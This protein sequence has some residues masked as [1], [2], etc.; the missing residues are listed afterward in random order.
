MT[1]SRMAVIIASW[2]IIICSLLIG[3]WAKKKATDV[4]SFF[5]S[6]ALFGPITIGL[7]TMA[8]VAS[9]F[10]VV[11]VPGLLYATGNTIS[12]WILSSVAFSMSYIILGKKMRAMAELGPVATLGDICDLRFNRHKGIKL[13]FSVIIFIG[14]IA[15]LA[16]QIKGVSELFAHLMGWSP[17]LSAF[18]IFGV[19]TLYTAIS[20]EVGGIMT[21]AFQGFV[22]VLA[23]FIMIFSFYSIT[24]GMFNAVSVISSAGKITAGGITKVF[25]PNMLNAWGLLPGSTALAFIIMP[26]IGLLGQPQVLT[27]MYALKNPNDMAKLALYASFSH[28]FVSFLAVVT[29]VGAMYLVAKGLVSPI[30]VADRAVFVFADYVGTFGQVFVYACVLSAAMSSASMFLSLSAG[31]LSRDIPNALGYKLTPDKQINYA[32]VTIVVLGLLAIIVTFT[33]GQMLAILTTFGYGTFVS[34]TFPVFVIGLLWDRCSSQGVLSGLST[35]LILNI[36]SLYLIQTGFKWPGGFPW[37]MNVIA[38]SIIITVG[39]SL[40]TKGSSGET[41]DKRVKEVIEL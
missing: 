20:G 41:L 40:F 33:S 18:V 26:S 8:G 7:S 3:W 15:Y 1:G 39:V 17:M 35:A 37:Y 5:G 32:R 22:M 6:T 30:S 4:Q 12:L 27:R 38:A 2:G 28:I 11:G 25:N 16:S 10:A 21:Q 19:L 23:G 13:I 14:C 31:M 34:A 24:G 9:A 36:V 29:G